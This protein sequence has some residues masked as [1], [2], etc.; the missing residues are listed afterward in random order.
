M[1]CQTKSNTKTQRTLK[2]NRNGINVVMWDHDIGQRRTVEHI[3]ITAGWFPLTL[4]VFFYRFGLAIIGWR[5]I[6]SVQY[7]GN[8]CYRSV[9]YIIASKQMEGV[10]FRSWG[11]RRWHTVVGMFKT[12]NIIEIT[13]YD[14]LLKLIFEAGILL[15]FWTHRFWPA[16]Y[17]ISFIQRIA[18]TDWLRS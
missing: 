7:C 13:I 11:I 14:L 17:C 4:E 8:V 15:Y 9:E 2:S 3:R 1:A 5:G 18:L 12:A 6:P 16:F 10:W